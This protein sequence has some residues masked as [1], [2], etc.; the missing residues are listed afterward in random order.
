MLTKG[1]INLDRATIKLSLLEEP[2]NPRIMRKRYEEILEAKTKL[3]SVDKNDEAQ[4]KLHR[5]NI[6]FMRER[7]NDW[8]KHYIVSMEITLKHPTYNGYSTEVRR[9]FDLPGPDNKATDFKKE[10][11]DAIRATIREFRA[12][13][14]LKKVPRK[15]Y[16]SIAIFYDAS[17]KGRVF[18]HGEQIL[19]LHVQKNFKGIYNQKAPSINKNHVGI[20]LEFCAPVTEH[21]LAYELSKAGIDKY[22]QLKEDRSLRPKEKENAFELAILLPETNYKTKLGQIIKILEKYKAN[23]TDR[24]CGLHIHLDMRNRSHRT[25]YN[26]FIACQ[27]V[28]L[29]LIDPKRID[30]EFCRAVKSR[31]WP[32]EFK[33][34]REER[35]KTVNAASFYKYRTIEIRMHEGSVNFKAICH[36]VD[37]LLKIA[38]YKKKLKSNILNLPSLKKRFKLESGLYDYAV[39]RSGFFSINNGE[40]IRER[41]PEWLR[42]RTVDERPRIPRPL[43][44]DEAPLFQEQPTMTTILERR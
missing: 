35:Y 18:S 20:E 14:K 33:G 44:A 32:D 25:V 9:R 5:K 7:Y 3:K 37:I 29:K 43:V 27:G 15:F 30:T 19:Q 38:N 21:R 11:K 36:W 13:R 34:N 42:D 26:N 2:A 41:M 4:V 6:K 16:N 24:R 23:A 31:K 22:A 12:N 8:D 17:K 39:D 28:L 10:I 1:T 40:D